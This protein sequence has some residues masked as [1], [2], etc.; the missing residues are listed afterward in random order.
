M[1]TSEIAY[2]KVLQLG[3]CNTVMVSLPIKYC[4]EYGIKKGDTVKVIATDVLTIK[5]IKEEG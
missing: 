5:P 3:N 4:R 1:K 2:R